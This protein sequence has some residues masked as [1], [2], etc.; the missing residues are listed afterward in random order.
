MFYWSNCRFVSKI[1]RFPIP[2]FSV[3]NVRLSAELCETP[4]VQLLL[5]AGVEVGQGNH[6]RPQ[7]AHFSVERGMLFFD[8]VDR[9]KT[10]DE[11]PCESRS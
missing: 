6:Y 1:I 2:D 7:S 3:K 10:Y 8:T 11:T 5:D 9:R 4:V